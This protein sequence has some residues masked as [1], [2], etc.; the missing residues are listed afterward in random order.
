MQLDSVSGGPK[1]QNAALLGMYTVDDNQVIR[2]WSDTAKSLLGHGGSEILGRLCLQALRPFGHDDSVPV[3]LKICRFMTLG[4]E[5]RLP[6]PLRVSML[7]ASGQRKRLVL[8]PLQI[9]AE[10]GQTVFI[11]LFHELSGDDAIETTITAATPQSEATPLT[12]R[13]LEVLRLMAAGLTNQE[14]AERLTI[15]Y[16]TVRN[17]VC[18][19]RGKLQARNR[20]EAASIGRIL[21]LV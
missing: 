2:Y 15:S 10:G 11:H 20:E 4:A 21:G 17:H 13:E 1:S 9:P 18:N 12:G 19:I 14:I 5:R 6:Y 7:C 8:I 16:H 3:C